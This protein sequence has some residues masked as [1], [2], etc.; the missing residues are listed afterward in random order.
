MTSYY[1]YSRFPC[2]IRGDLIY[3]LKNN[4]KSSESERLLLS[5]CRH[6][7]YDFKIDW[8]TFKNFFKNLL[9]TGIAQ[10]FPGPLRHGH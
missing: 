3:W 4:V 6:G 2:L 7:V 8:R 1:F 9:N 10:N 5:R